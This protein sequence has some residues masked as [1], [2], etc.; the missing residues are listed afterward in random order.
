MRTSKRHFIR[1]L[2]RIVHSFI[3]L[4]RCL[5][6][7]R[8]MQAAS[9]STNDMN[10]TFQ[11]ATQSKHESIICT[12]FET[13]RTRTILASFY[14]SP[15]LWYP[16]MYRLIPVET[17]SIR[18]SSFHRKIGSCSCNC[19]CSA[20]PSSLSA[21]FGSDNG[22]PAGFISFFLSANDW[23][24]EEILT[25]TWEKA[26]GSNICS[27]ISIF[28]VQPLNEFNEEKWKRN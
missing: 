5:L 15:A 23:Y 6:I 9:F 25:R 21:T 8:S 12:G 10:R 11:P 14:S 27:L 4:H 7:F 1:N 28:T 24:R 13:W 22:L 26:E 16:H 3:C 17:D 2:V 20:R 19:C 18:E